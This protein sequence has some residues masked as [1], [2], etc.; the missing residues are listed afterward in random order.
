[1]LRPEFAD[2]DGLYEPWAAA[3]SPD[4]QLVVLNEP[5]AIEM[6]LDVAELRTADGVAALVGQ[7]LPEGTTTLAQAYAGHQFGGFSSSLGDGRALLLGEL[8]DRQGRHHDL[9]LKG[10]GPTPFA[11]GGD[12]RAAL[13]PMLREHLV[14]EAMHAMGIPTTR[15][16]AVVTT[17][18]P[19]SAR[20]PAP[21][22]R[23]GPRRQQPPAS[24]DV[25]VRRRRTATGG[26]CNASPTTP[27]PATTP[28]P[29]RP[30]LRR[31]VRRRRRGAG[32]TRR[33]LDA[34]RVRPRCDEH[35]QHDDLRPDD[36]LRAVRLHRRVRPGDRVQLD[37]PRRPLRL[38]QPT[39][40][41]PLEPGAAGEAMLP[42]LADE[43]EPAVEAANG[44]L[45]TFADRYQHH[46]LDGMRAKLG[47]RTPD[48]ADDALARDLLELMHAQQ[49]D[50]TSS[51]R[52]LSAAIT[53]RGAVHPC[54]PNRQRSTPGP[55]AGTAG[56]R[57]R[58][59]RRPRW[60][61]PWIAP[62][63]CTSPATTSS[64][65]LWPPPPVVTCSP[66]APPRRRHP[67]VRR[68]PRMG[69][70]RPTGAARRRALPHVLRDLSRG[71]HQPPRCHG[72]LRR[73]GRGARSPGRRA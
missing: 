72:R 28:P 3:P 6:G 23:A 34:R 62:T 55:R 52:A 57:P 19:V 46:W 4:P 9:H 58:A 32:G 17:G 11:R 64:N 47:L 22:R 10:S 13:G 66:T 44:V 56:W 68:P 73:R 43:L 40:H 45:A 70:V 24:R 60:P 41:R 42:L 1:M 25:P 12:G 15:A 53:D 50:F 27:S 39:S 63:R 71:R 35:R 20:R 16:L 18:E 61:Q 21:R 33:T 36:R 54:S 65:R 37:R 30:T 2:L 38:R 26:R 69:R 48:P 14:S 5:L 7:R 29:V 8:V 49:L 51:F 67:T 31:P 59:G